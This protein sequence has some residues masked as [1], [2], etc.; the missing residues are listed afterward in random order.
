MLTQAGYVAFNPWILDDIEARE[1]GDD[2]ETAELEVSS[3]A[4]KDIVHSFSA[5]K[6]LTC[7]TKC[8]RWGVPRQGKHIFPPLHF[9][10]RAIL[11]RWIIWGT[12]I[13]RDQCLLDAARREHFINIFFVDP[14]R[15]EPV[16]RRLENNQVSPDMLIDLFAD[17]VALLNVGMPNF[18]PALC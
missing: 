13:I 14:R 16:H 18:N 17:V 8:F 5:E 11:L 12:A 9:T 15:A 2:I 1:R 7:I 4:S 10:T 6:M 3:I